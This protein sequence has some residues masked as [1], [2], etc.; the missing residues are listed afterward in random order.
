[1][2]MF[3]SP[4]IER[5][6]EERDYDGLYRCLEHRDVLVRLQAAQALADMEDGAG[7]RFLMETVRDSTDLEARTVAASMLGELGH[8]RA[9]PVLGDALFKGR[10]DP[11][12]EAFLTAV[13]DALEA[14]GGPEAEDALRRAG[15]EPVLP[16][17]S[18]T[19]IEYDTHFARPVLPRDGEITFLTD[20]QHL[21][22]A[23]DLREAELAERGLVEASLALMLKPEWSYA[24]YLRGVLFEDLDRNFE[25]AL[26]Y[27][28]AIELDS[29][30]DDAREALEEL[31][32]AEGAPDIDPPDM[33]LARMTVR[34]WQER[35]D[36]AAAAGEQAMRGVPD[37]RQILLDPLLTL[38]K[39]EEREVRHAAVEALGRM[40]DPRAVP[41]LL[42]MGESSWLVRFAILNT[43]SALGSVEGLVTALRRE[44]TK[45]Q[46]R[47][48][49]FSSHKDPLLEVE[50]GV[51][52][53]IGVRALERTG[54]IE[55]LLA[56]SEDN[57]W[58]EVDDEDVEPL[59]PG[60]ESYVR[61]EDGALVSLDDEV[62]EEADEDLTA[63]VDEVAEMAAIA[64][65]RLALPAIPQLGED[66]LTRLAAIPDLTL[67][68]LSEE[69]A[70]PVIVK[71]LSALRQAAVKE[72]EGR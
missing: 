2:N 44:M 61:L 45:I 53:E 21:N 26:A 15:Y 20:E 49:V 3:G 39:D 1:M 57:A 16:V 29:H 34:N 42:E 52:M 25:A 63:Y 47:N 5:M 58:E 8:P 65:E 38:L 55:A 35:R 13:Q 56:L 60:G 6:A 22:N 51:L 7:W 14:I 32:L 31:S 18:H 72:L 33:L 28:R 17:Q 48:P 41:P 69:N 59:S 66:I 27:R 37:A 62:E 24:W 23:V 70:E 46:E 30:M 10:I 54:N 68:D 67:I 12:S 36:A 40:G 64:L 9:I 50:Y 71:D 4:D 43:L 11:K 19:I